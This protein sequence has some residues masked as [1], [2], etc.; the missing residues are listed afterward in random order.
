VLNE[1]FDLLGEDTI[2]AHL[3]DPALEDE[4]V[5]HIAEVVAGTG[6]L[7]YELLLTRL[8]G[9]GKDFYCLIE[10]LPDEQVAQARDAVLHAAKQS[11]VRFKQG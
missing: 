10:H 2:A 8:A 3:K 1:L 9:L 7:D 4:L 6:T 5:V 11:G